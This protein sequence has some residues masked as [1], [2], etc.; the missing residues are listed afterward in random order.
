MVGRHLI[1]YLCAGVGNGIGSPG[2]FFGF[3]IDR[4]IGRFR[5]ILLII[6]PESG[7]FGAEPYGVQVRLVIIRLEPIQNGSQLLEE[8]GCLFV[9]SVALTVDAAAQV[10]I[11]IQRIE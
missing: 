9:R 6:L 7:S 11:N 10:K 4:I 1:P 8:G 2:I 5:V 3:G